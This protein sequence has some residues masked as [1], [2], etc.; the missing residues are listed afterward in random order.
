MNE[1]FKHAMNIMRFLANQSACGHAYNQH[2]YWSKRSFQA[3]KE[4]KDFNAD[5]WNKVFKLDDEERFMLG[6]RRW[7]EHSKELLIPLWIVECLPDDFDIKVTGIM[8]GE[9]SIKEIDKD[10]RF[11]CVA[12]MV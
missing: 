4:E 10:V 6:F 5:F 9:F 8:G 7:D 2:E 1:T 3:V 12:Y 11:G